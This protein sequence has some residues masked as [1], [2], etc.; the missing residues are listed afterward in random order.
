M[1]LVSSRLSSNVS[2][3]FL[4]TRAQL[5]Q[6][7]PYTASF[8]KAAFVA[9]TFIYVVYVFFGAFIYGYS[10]QYTYVIASLGINN[11]AFVTITNVVGLVS[12][13]I[14]AV[15]CK[16]FFYYVDSLDFEF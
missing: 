12:G 4:A 8:W 11:Y 2:L 15:L 10:G 6:P 13:M 9:Q 3:L 1:S 16:C 7:P 14:A 5:L